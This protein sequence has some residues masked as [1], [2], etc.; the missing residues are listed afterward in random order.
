[1][2]PLE[3]SSQAFAA[4]AALSSM[5]LHRCA[6]GRISLHVP[7]TAAMS[8]PLLIA[9]TTKSTTKA[10]ERNVDIEGLGSHITYRAV[11]SAPSNLPCLQQQDSLSGRFHRPRGAH[12]GS[13]PVC[14]FS[15]SHEGA[16]ALCRLSLHPTWQ[17]AVMSVSH[18]SCTSQKVPFS[19]LDC[20][21]FA[22][23]ILGILTV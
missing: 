1:M 22:L 13:R 5:W 21:C 16:S 2:A 20:G 18:Q 11:F 23:G 12:V 6:R 10:P 15:V 17:A 14:V 3:A 19:F 4:F 9:A 7:V 8:L